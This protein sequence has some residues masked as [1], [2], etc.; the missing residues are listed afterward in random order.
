MN[1]ALY[2]ALALAVAAVVYVLARGVIGMAQGRDMTGRTSNKFMSYRVTFQAL[3][4]LIV[5]L[6]AYMAG[7]FD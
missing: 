4:I 5:V 7:Q 1:T 3:A 6:M 2:I